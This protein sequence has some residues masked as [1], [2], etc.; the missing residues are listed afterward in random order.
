MTK[1]ISRDEILLSQKITNNLNT[2]VE[3]KTFP[4]TLK[5]TQVKNNMEMFCHERSKEEESR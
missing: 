4:G 3:L 5:V 1:M 2:M